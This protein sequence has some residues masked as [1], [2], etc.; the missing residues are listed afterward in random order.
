MNRRMLIAMWCCFFLF[1]QYQL[2]FSAGGGIAVQKKYR[3]I[4]QQKLLNQQLETRNKVLL[5]QID[6]LKN[7]GALLE[8]HAR[9]DLGMIKE[10]EVF[11]Q[12]VD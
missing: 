5:S 7:G 11:Y 9:H 8:E 2:W 1:L 3:V 6:D 12:V 10:R 4:M